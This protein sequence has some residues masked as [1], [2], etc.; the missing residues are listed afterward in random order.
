MAIEEE[1]KKKQTDELTPPE[2]P[3]GAGGPRTVEHRALAKQWFL[4]AL[5]LCHIVTGACDYAGISPDTAYKWKEKDKK[6]AEAWDVAVARTHD[7]A[8]ASIFQRAF[9]GIDSYI[10][11][12]GKVAVDREGNPLVEKKYSDSLAAL[13]AKTQLPEFQEK[14]QV[15]VRVQLVEEAE[16]AK[17]ELLASLGVIDENS[18]EAPQG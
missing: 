12:F 5:P 1:K 4:E 3:W 10:V 9:L 6:F 15:D 14:K 13:Y 11:S 17:Q 2:H 18:E 8:R 7:I 16:K